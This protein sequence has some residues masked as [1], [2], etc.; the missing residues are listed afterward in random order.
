MNP[1]LFYIGPSFV[2]YKGKTFYSSKNI[3]V[4]QQLETFKVGSVAFG[5]LEEREKFLSLIVEMEPVG[6]LDALSIL[7]PYGAVSIG[8]LLHAN[9][10]ISNVN[11]GTGLLTVASTARFRA[12]SPVLVETYGVLPTGVTQGTIYFLNIA[13]GTTC[14]LYDT[15]AHAIAG[16]GTGLLTPSVAG[17]G[18]SKIIDQEPLLIQPLDGSQGFVF[19]NAAIPQSPDIIAAGSATPIGT[20]KFECFRAFDLATTNAASFFSRAAAITD[21]SFADSDIVTDTYSLVW[22]ATAPWSAM[23]LKAGAKVTFAQ[24]LDPVVQDG[25]GLLTRR[26]TAQAATLVARPL[27]V[28]AEDIWAKLNIQG[29]GAGQGRRL[30]G[31]DTL[32]LVGA[33]GGLA[34]RLYGAAFKNPGL[35][36]D[37]K[38]ERS[39]DLTW[40]AARTFAAGVAKPLYYVA[41]TLGAAP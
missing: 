30:P 36:Y 9:T 11:T 40:F 17:T 33:S 5:D 27:N 8:D 14:S 38:E 4:S 35:N 19:A 24:T 31:T 12:G 15:A 10:T 21:T 1:V 16:G 23:A 25:I 34:C 32:D 6:K 18:V 37:I 29:G 20:L 7:W 28:G 3:K 2:T 39:P 13:S 41:A 26:I 22:G